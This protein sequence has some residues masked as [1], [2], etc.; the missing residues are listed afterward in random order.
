MD[1]RTEFYSAR[2]HLDVAKRMLNMYNEYTEKRILIGVIREIA[3]ASG[4]LVRAFLIFDETCG[5]LKTF[6]EKVGPKYL[7]SVD[8]NNLVKILDIER[9]QRRAR[10]E[11]FKASQKTLSI[12][13][14]SANIDKEGKILLEA[15]GKW[16]I[17]RV[18]RLREFVNG[19]DNLISNFPTDIKR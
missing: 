10:V 14:A 13:E 1:Y 2:W 6:V 8:I 12:Q 19:V 3:K 17:L 5:N 16:K 4:K 7:D 11:L 15:D 18:S 9:A